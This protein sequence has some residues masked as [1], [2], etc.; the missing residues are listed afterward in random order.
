[1]AL[2][3]EERS[4]AVDLEKDDAAPCALDSRREGFGDV[5]ES[6]FRR[7]HHLRTRLADHEPSGD[8][9]RLCGGDSRA[10]AELAR[11]RR[12]RRQWCMR[13]VTLVDGERPA[14]ELGLCATER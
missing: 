6:F 5:E 8:H 13:I 12:D 7:A 11:Q 1:M 4:E 10:G 2:G 3:P 9:P 14:A